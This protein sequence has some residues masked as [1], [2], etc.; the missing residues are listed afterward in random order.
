VWCPQNKKPETELLKLSCP[1]SMDNLEIQY[2][3]TAEHV[4]V[5]RSVDGGNMPHIL[6]RVSAHPVPCFQFFP[7]ELLGTTGEIPVQHSSWK[8]FMHVLYCFLAL[9]PCFSIPKKKELFNITTK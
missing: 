2:S 5:L 3:D 7:L 8:G 1:I 6:D 4:G 9:M